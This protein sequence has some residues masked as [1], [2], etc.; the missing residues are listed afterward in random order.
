VL[1]DQQDI[2]PAVGRWPEHTFVGGHELDDEGT[3][4]TTPARPSADD[5]AY[6][7]FTS[8]S[9]GVPKGVMVTHRNAM[10]FV[11]SV[12]ERYGITEDDRFSQT[13][14]T[15]FDLSVFDMFV[16]WQRGACVCCPSRVVL[17]NPGRFIQ[18]QR[19]T[20]WFSV[21]S[22]GMLMKRIGALKP[23]VFPSLRWSLFCGERLPSETAAAWAAAAPNS[24][25]EN[26]Y[27]PTELTVACT[28]YRWD[29][30]RSPAESTFGVVPIGG[31]LPGMD[32]LV[33]DETLREVLPGEEGELLM[34]GPQQTPGYWQDASATA[35]A[36]VTVPGRPGRFYR[37]GDRVRRPI[38]DGPITFLGRVDHQI[39]VRGHRVELG[40]V[41]SMLLKIPGVESAAAV[42]WPVALSGALGI[43]AFVTGGGL[44][45]A[46]VRT[47]VQAT[48]QD[49]AVPQTI[50][51]LSDLPLNA[52]GKVDRRALVALLDAGA[53]PRATDA[54][55]ASA[56]ATATADGR[57]SK[58]EGSSRAPAYES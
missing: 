38:G 39:K 4:A 45:P 3:S 7:L 12:V 24:T 5:I 23:G 20:V 43:A 27:G 29:P 14:D 35:A 30:E 49:Y 16:A 21:P 50:Q 1:P 28:A 10:Q 47:A 15:T 41:E 25:V 19:L 26:L 51:V 13:F 46:V 11:A 31:P 18:D 8:G 54:G 40:E 37:T 2:A 34:A 17:W 58:S 53:A 22:L 57:S 32:V 44:E 42:G 6:L 48:L 56:S 52:N 33:A 55:A 36:Y 9:T